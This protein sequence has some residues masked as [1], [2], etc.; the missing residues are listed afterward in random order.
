MKLQEILSPDVRCVA[1]HQTLTE[2]AGLMRELDV[3]AVPVCD[4]DRLAGML[5]DRDLT[6][7]AV[8]DGRDP[9]R[10]TVRETMSEGIVYVYEDEDVEHAAEVMEKKQ[11]RRL[12]VLNREKRLVGIVSLGDIATR[13]ESDMGGEA[14]KEVSEH[15]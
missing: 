2:A 5:T 7:R 9:T 11:I 6:I 3:G 12:P 8:A 14:L 4:N 15:R 1:P 13:A 10:T